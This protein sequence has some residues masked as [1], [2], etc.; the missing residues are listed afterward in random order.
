[1]G[2]IGRSVQYDHQTDLIINVGQSETKDFW[3]SYKTGIII[4]YFN[5]SNAFYNM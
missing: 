5:I 2:I 4:F 3:T 1:M